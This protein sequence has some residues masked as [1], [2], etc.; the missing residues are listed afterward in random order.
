MARSRLIVRTK[1]PFCSNEVEV[2]PDSILK[3]QPGYNNTEFVVTR[4]GYKQYMHSSCWYG[5]IEE[6]KKQRKEKVTV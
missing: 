6:Q 2:V 1:C 5:M 4:T 3:K